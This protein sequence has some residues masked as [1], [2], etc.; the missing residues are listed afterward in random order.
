MDGIRN[1]YSAEIMSRN[2]DAIATDPRDGRPYF[3]KP[4]EREEKFNDFLSYL[5]KQELS[6]N[7]SSSVKYAQTRIPP[8]SPF[9]HK[10]LAYQDTAEN[11]N[12]R[13]EYSE[14]FKDVEQDITWARIALDQKCGP[15]AINLWIGNSRSVTALHRDNYENIYVQVMGEKH[16]VLVSPVETACIMEKELPSATYAVITPFHPWSCSGG[17]QLSCIAQRE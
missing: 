14:L 17:R 15:D 1:L 6:H 2:A 8:L 16:F 7:L 9:P 4:F 11:D 3:V 10:D 5:Q 12:L 13:G